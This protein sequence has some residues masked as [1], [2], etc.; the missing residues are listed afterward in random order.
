MDT[1]T[2]AFYY[3]DV[4]HAASGPFIMCPVDLHTKL[5]YF[6]APWLL[7]EVC[8]RDIPPLWSK[9]TMWAFMALSN[10]YIITIESLS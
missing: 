7:V 2:G 1:R 8:K 3:F 5:G 4:Q 10:F 6:R 9:L